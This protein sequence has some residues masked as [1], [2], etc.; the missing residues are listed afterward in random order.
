MFSKVKDPQAP[1]TSAQTEIP[2]PTH[3][4]PASFVAAA[5]G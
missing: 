4:P 1:G 2:E 3:T 5:L